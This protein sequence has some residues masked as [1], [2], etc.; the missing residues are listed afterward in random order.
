MRPLLKYCGNHSLA[1]LQHVVKSNADYIGVVFAE[2]KRRVTPLELFTWLAEVKLRPEQKLVGLFVNATFSE[3]E[4]VISKIPLDIIQC[5]GNETVS[6]V[7]ELKEKLNLPIWKVI[8]HDEEAVQ[9]MEQYA[10]FVSAYVIDSKV[11]DQWGGTGQ[12]FDWSHIPSY[13]DEGIHLNRPVF[14]AGGINGENVHELVAYQ[15][16]GIDISS[17]IEEDGSKSSVKMTEI[18]KRITEHEHNLS[19]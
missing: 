8:H 7:R 4:N 19:R 16:D 3:I 18:E 12:V 9:T 10:P 5:H 13:I 17:G 2:S 15:P 11:K 14:I 1:D 6:V